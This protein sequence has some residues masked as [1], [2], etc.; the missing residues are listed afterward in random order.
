ML[1]STDGERI[2]RSSNAATFQEALDH[3]ETRVSGLRTEWAA[4]ESDPSLGETAADSA[5]FCSPLPRAYEWCEGSTYIAHMERMRGARGME[6]PPAHELE[7]IIYQAGASRLLSPREPVPLPDP[8]WGLDLE[9]TVAVIVDDVPIG[10]TADEASDHI[11]FVMLTN[12]FTY[13]NLMPREYAKRVGPYQAKPTRAY[14]P[15]AVSGELLGDMWDGR[16]LHVTVRSWVNGTLLG[17]VDAGAD[18]VFDFAILIEYLTRTRAL[19][20]GTIVGAGTV[21]NRDASNGFAC[22]GE[23]RALELA[24]T[25]KTQTDWLQ[26]GDVVRIEAFDSSNRSVFGALEQTI[27]APQHR[28]RRRAAPETKGL[29]G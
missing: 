8:T 19:A 7:P 1:V 4:L 9:A 23:K 25:D 11:L 10:T 27:V 13:R 20:A 29:S 24:E 12:D 17:A 14:A 28:R 5:G 21:A 26:V 22:L 15:F 18:N 2:M 3:W 16:L 6:L